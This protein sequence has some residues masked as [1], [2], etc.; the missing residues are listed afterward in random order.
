MDNSVR[1][2]LHMWTRISPEPLLREELSQVMSVVP[3]SLYVLSLLSFDTCLS[4]LLLHCFCL[5]Y[6]LLESDTHHLLQL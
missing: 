4:L 3:G 5:N 1:S 2:V 6:R